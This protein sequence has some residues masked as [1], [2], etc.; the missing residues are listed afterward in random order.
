MERLRYGVFH[1]GQIWTVSDD[2]GAKLG[3]PSRGIATVA[4]AAI[5]AGHRA[6][7]QDV[8]VTL[9]DEGGRLRTMVNPNRHFILAPVGNDEAWDAILGSGADAASND[10]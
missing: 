4:L 3:F 5:V 1:V 8:L 6:R 9:Q 10:D 7:G 2:N